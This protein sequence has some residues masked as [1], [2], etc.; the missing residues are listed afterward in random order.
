MDLD[1]IQLTSLICYQLYP[2]S[3]IND[4]A[5]IEKPA[6]IKVE[7]IPAGVRY[8]GENHNQITFIVNNHEHAFL[9]DPEMEL[10]TGLLAA[11]NFSMVDISL[12]NF[13]K[14]TGL[15][16]VDIL[17][18]FQSRHILMFG[19]NTEEIGLPFTIPFFQI[20]KFQQQTYL[21]NPAMAD[22]IGNKEL[23]MKLWNCL[24]TLFLSN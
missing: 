4:S 3:L 17:N 21:F 5:N 10:L 23:K 14:N 11:C 16:Y 12:V 18:Q 7:K 9:S 13:S 22:L 20:Q 19:V 2:E 8:L 1:H 6:L 24:K 15:Q